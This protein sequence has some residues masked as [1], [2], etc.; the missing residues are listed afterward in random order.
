MKVIIASTWDGEPLAPAD[1]VSI[2]LTVE[3]DSVLITVEA[4]FYD[5]PAPAEP[6]GS[7]HGLWEFEVVEVFFVEA[8]TARGERPH[9]TEVELGPHGHHLGL[10]L[11]GVRNAV[12]TGLPIRWECA[13]SEG[14]WQGTAEIR[15]EILPP[16]PWVVNAFA[17]S[18]VGVQR[19]YA[20]ATRLPGPKPDFHQPARFS[21]PLG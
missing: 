20:C 16:G 10:K 1:Q 4:P 6:P 5:D 7:R 13:H 3:A 14:H 21:I 19:R 18:G 15:R 12:A 8:A 11:D 9:Y 2:T 17:I